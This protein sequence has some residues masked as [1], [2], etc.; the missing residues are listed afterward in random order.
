MKVRKYNGKLQEF[1]K[2]K[3]EVAI[4]K[5]AQDAREKG[6]TEN[7][8]EFMMKRIAQQVEEEFAQKDIK[9][10]SI[11]DISTLVENKLMDSQYK[12]TAYT[13]ITYH[14]EKENRMARQS[15]LIKAFRKK[16]YGTNIENSNANMDEGSFSGRMFEAGRVLYK[17]EALNMMSKISRDNHNNNLIYIHD[18]DNYAGG[19]HNCLSIP[20]D[21]TLAQGIKT[22]QTDIREA[23]SL[24]T[25]FQLIAVI[26]QIQSLMQF[27]GVAATHID[28]TLM[29]YVRY[30]FFRHLRFAHKYQTDTVNKYSNVVIL[31]AINKFQW[32]DEDVSRLEE[33]LEFSKMGYKKFRMPKNITKTSIDDYRDDPCW[34]YA[35]DMTLREARQGAEGL[36]HNLNSLQSRSGSQLPFSSINYGTCTTTEGRMVTDAIL[37]AELDGTGP[38]HKTPIFPCCIFQ[39]SKKI[40]GKKGTPNY[41]LFRKALECTAKRLYPNYANV[42]WSVDLKFRQKDIDTKKQYLEKMSPENMAKLVE[43]VSQN[44]DEAIKYRMEVDGDKVVI[45]EDVII[46]VEIMSTMGCRTYNGWDANFDFGYIIKTILKTGKAPENYFYSGNQKDGR[47]NICP[48]TI[49]LPTVAMMS[50]GTLGN[51]NIEDFMAKLDKKIFEARDQLIERFTHI[52]SQ[53]PASAPFMYINNTMKGYIPEEGIISALKHGTTVIGHLGMAECLQILIGKDHSTEEGM[54]L[55]KR[56]ETLLNSRCAEFKAQEYEIT[57]TNG[58]VHKIHL[59]FGNYF[60][61]AESLCHTACEKFKKKYGEIPNVSDKKFFTNSIHIPVWEDITPFEKIDL[62]S[63]L[64]GFSNA[65]CITY[66]ELDSTASHNIDA[67]EEFVVYAMEKD[68]PYLGLNLPNDTCQECGWI[69][70]INDKCPACGSDEICRLRRVTGYLTNDYLTTFNAGKVDEV[71][72]RVRHIGQISGV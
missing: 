8:P 35:Y 23:H 41:D 36:I 71:Q 15:E 31:N 39:Y 3:I 38:L 46:P 65:G 5:S 48:N 34:E 64:T 30:S 70:E 17:D 22:R 25:A 66:V 47:G 51:K 67:L 44:E 54:E 29:P 50:K 14:Y 63:Q 6:S 69:G 68:I 4:S 13:Y 1:D 45:N 26:M 16:L 21:D 27:G 56:I 11:Q 49:I 52:A 24:N 42:D 59:N 9:T 37:D 32:S 18:L 55:A 53:S 20:F 60:T 58:T 2:T 61:P 40:N 7:M 19:S 12:D 43:W 72:H 10:V 62:E 33:L 28:W 57:L